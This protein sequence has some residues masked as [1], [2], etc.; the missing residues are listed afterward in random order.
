MRRTKDLLVVIAVLLLHPAHAHDPDRHFYGAWPQYSQEHL[1]SVKAQN[2][3]NRAVT[4]E[5][6]RLHPCPSTGKKTGACPGWIKDHIKP[7]CAGGADAVWNM[8]WQSTRDAALKDKDEYR[9]CR[10]L[11]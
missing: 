10:S 8:Q 3:R 1:E 5:F 7:L 9:L 2:K 4:R 6:Q 11:R